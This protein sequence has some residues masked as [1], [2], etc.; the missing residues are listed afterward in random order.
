MQYDGR[1]LEAVI[2]AQGRTVRWLANRINVHES[3]LSRMINGVRPLTEEVAE[4]VAP[5]LGI[6]VSFLAADEPVVKVAS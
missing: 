1:K 6:P 5:V 2:E 3:T 4:A